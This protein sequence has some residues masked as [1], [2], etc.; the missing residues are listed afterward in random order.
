MHV[1]LLR[2]PQYTV[3]SPGVVYGS[4][5]YGRITENVGYYRV[6]LVARHVI[7]TTCPVK[8]SRRLE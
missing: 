8:F 6:F 2:S 1:R 7:V 4:T 3:Y 5:Y